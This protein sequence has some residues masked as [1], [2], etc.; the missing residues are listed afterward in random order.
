MRN[1]FRRLLR[2]YARSLRV[3]AKS[4]EHRVAASFVNQFAD[5][6]SLKLL[7]TPIVEDQGLL[8]SLVDQAEAVDNRRKVENF[9]RNRFGTDKLHDELQDNE[10]R[11]DDD[12]VYD[13]EEYDGSLEE[14][15]H[16]RLFLI[17]SSAFKTFRQKLHDFVHPS[18][19]TTVRDVLRT[20][21]EP[22]NKM[23]KLVRQYELSSLVTELQYI[24]TTQIQLESKRGV[25][26][27]HL[28]S[29]ADYLK[30]N[31]ETW[32]GGSWDWWP[33]KPAKRRLR[34]KEDRVSWTCVR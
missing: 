12:D 10:D 31:A 34:D 9:L 1:N 29:M 7:P 8:G 26:P 22:E 20:W 23:S 18:M 13:D 14:M 5:K 28:T 2:H 4:S 25:G 6:I 17:G 30:C 3:E 21:L 15:Q 16:M 27:G 33:L 32:T 11:V 24:P 19:T